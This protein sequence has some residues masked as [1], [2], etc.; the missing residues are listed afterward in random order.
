MKLFDK[1]FGTYSERLLKKFDKTIAK[2]DEFGK[3]YEKMSD[4]ELQA[5]TPAFKE[6]LRQGETLDD[7]LPEAFALVREADWRVLSKRPFRVQLLGGIILHQGKIAEMKTGEGKTLVATLPAGVHIGM[8]AENIQRMR[9]DATGGHMKNAGEQFACNLVH[10]GNHQKKALRCRVG[11]SQSAGRQ[12]AVHRTG[13]TCLRLHLHHLHGGAEDVLQSLCRPLIHIVRHG[14]GRSD[15][16][17][18]GN[19]GKGVADMRRRI[20]AVHG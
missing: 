15:G 11:R 2:I 7:L 19:L 17:N 18:T 5:M 8:V 4:A 9:S 10:I 12:R 16:V 14:A 20:V 6:R 13:R 3:I 1:M